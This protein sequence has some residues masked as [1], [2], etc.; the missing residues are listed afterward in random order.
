MSHENF[1]SDVDLRS[2]MDRRRIVG[3]HVEKC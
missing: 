1:L 3:L 2:L